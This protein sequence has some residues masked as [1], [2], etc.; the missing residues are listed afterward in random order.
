MT[1][2]HESYLAYIPTNRTYLFLLVLR[3]VAA[4]CPGY[5]HPDEF[6]QAQEIT[7]GDVFGFSTFRA[8]EWSE[9]GTPYRSVFFP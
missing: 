5:A 1:H 3:C 8:W 4:L 2:D 7:A 6:F 9:K